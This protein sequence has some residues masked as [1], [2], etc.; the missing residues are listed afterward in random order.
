MSV[1]C[2]VYT[3]HFAKKFT[4]QYEPNTVKQQTTTTCLSADHF[5][6]QVTFAVSL[7]L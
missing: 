2:E 4:P 6:L 3:K 1:D 5:Y 7:A